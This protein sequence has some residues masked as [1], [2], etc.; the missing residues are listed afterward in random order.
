M[1]PNNCW[2]FTG[3]MSGSGYGAICDRGA[4]VVS[5]EHHKGPV[6]KGMIVCHTCDNKP[7]INPKHLFLGT[8]K[9]NKDDEIA[10]GR[11]VFGERQGQAK[12]TEQDVRDIRQFIVE[13]Y[14][15]A[16]IA[17]AY[18]MSWTAISYIRSGRN[19]GWLK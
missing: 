12:L 18:D 2:V 3:A 4:H 9:D 11:H 6:P 10:K 14:S 5:F 19:W 16:S 13:G 1:A 8:H 15:V 17:K 7:C